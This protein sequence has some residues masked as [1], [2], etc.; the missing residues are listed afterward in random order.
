ML[1]NNENVKY[2]N[3]D[4][5]NLKEQ[6]K[7]LWAK[8]WFILVLTSIITVSAIA[9]SFFK[10]PVYEAKAFIEIGEYKTFDKRNNLHT[11]K[12][13]N[14]KKLENKLNTVFIKT[15]QSKKAWIT[16][17]KIPKNQ[18]SLIEVKAQ[19]FSKKE[20]KEKINSV[21]LYIQNLHK[22]SFNEFKEIK[23]L[24]IANSDTIQLEK[25][26]KL[27]NNQIIDLKKYLKEYHTQ[28][29]LINKSIGLLEK[30]D[31]ILAS[32]KLNEKR[33][34]TSIILKINNDIYKLKYEL[35]GINHKIEK[36]RRILN[37]ILRDEN[38]KSTSLIGKTK[39]KDTPVKPKKK[40]II[41]VGF[42]TGFILSIFLVFF[43]N[44]INK[45]KEEENPND[46]PQ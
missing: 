36:E 19:A 45:F 16:S 35:I 8:K 32:L 46:T 28:L 24:E 12:I 30:S 14:A 6:F 33:N 25:E 40:L 26:E 11:V 13:D 1:T 4:E 39:L 3:E 23:Q 29:E 43:M 2:L 34:I 22:E 17:I 31:P 42:V 18:V 7:T 21:I 9:Y 20:L 5:I 10:I 15:P 37:F 38:Y 27:I 44:F 41:I